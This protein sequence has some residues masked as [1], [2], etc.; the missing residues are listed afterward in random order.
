MNKIIRKTW[1]NFEGITSEWFSFLGWFGIW[2]VLVIVTIY[3]IYYVKNKNPNFIYL[4]ISLASITI[5]SSI[6]L[7]IYTFKK[8]YIFFKRLLP[9]GKSKLLWF[10]MCMEAVAFCIIAVFVI[11]MIAFTLKSIPGV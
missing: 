9:P 1:N 7:I 4:K 11:A 8:C 10:F 3:E 2:A 6:L 5:F